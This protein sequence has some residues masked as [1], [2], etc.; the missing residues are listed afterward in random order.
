MGGDSS[1]NLALHEYVAHDII[2]GDPFFMQYVVTGV[3]KGNCVAIRVTKQDILDGPG[4]LF[5]GEAI[6]ILK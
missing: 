4:L 5:L 6:N 2:H 3:W 1:T